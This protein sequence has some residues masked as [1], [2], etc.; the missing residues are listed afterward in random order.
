MT[1]RLQVILLVAFGLIWFS[2]LEYRKLV[3][4][5]EPYA[6]WNTSVPSSRI[7]PG[8]VRARKSSAIAV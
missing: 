7:A 5:D 4:P 6:G 3:N 2:N 1:R 8:T